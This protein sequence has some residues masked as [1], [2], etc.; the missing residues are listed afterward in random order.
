M[1]MMKTTGDP[2]TPGT[3]QAGRPRVLVVDDD[4]WCR[5][6]TVAQPREAGFRSTLAGRGRRAKN[7][8]PLDPSAKVLLVDDRDV[9][10][11]AVRT[12]AHRLRGRR[13]S[14]A[15]VSEQE[16]AL[17][18]ESTRRGCCPAENDPEAGEDRSVRQTT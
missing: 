16:D 2:P 15:P 10:P 3:L 9:G 11:I 1:A 17:R 13:R 5:L 7:L 8:R 12:G 6:V 4:S 18:W 14:A